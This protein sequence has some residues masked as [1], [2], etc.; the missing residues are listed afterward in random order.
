MH[1]NKRQA[2]SL[3]FPHFPQHSLVYFTYSATSEIQKF[4]FYFH[5]WVSSHWSKN[6][7]GTLMIEC[8]W[9][10]GYHR[11]CLSSICPTSHWI[12]PHSACLKC[13]YTSHPKTISTD[14]LG[15]LPPCC[16]YAEFNQGPILYSKD[17]L[18]VLI[19]YWRIF[20]LHHHP[21]M[22]TGQ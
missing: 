19:T 11:F 14:I 20:S 10:C 3:S 6:N 16:I 5:K 2:K 12:N 21:T 18:T 13:F 4:Y 7:C 9:Y 22:A 8:A 17:S 1:R 15:V